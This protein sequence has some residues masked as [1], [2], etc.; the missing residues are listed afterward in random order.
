[1]KKKHLFII[2]FFGLAVT[3]MSVTAQDK[4]L[5]L[6]KS[7]EIFASAINELDKNYIENIEVEALSE[8]AT[9]AL[10]DKL[11]SY[12]SYIPFNTF[13]HVNEDKYDNGAYSGIG[14]EISEKNGKKYFSRVYK[15]TP[16]HRS[17]LQPGDEILKINGVI[18]SH[19]TAI[20]IA[21]L[22][23]GN[24][25]TTI[26]IHVQRFGLKEP[27]VVLVTR[28]KLVSYN[29]VYYNIIGNDIAYIK[30]Q[31]FGSN[32]A[33]EVKQI[34][35]NLRSKGA[36][37]LILDLRDNEGGILDE[38]V[39]LLDQFLEPETL[40][41]RTIGKTIESTKEYRISSDASDTGMPIVI[42]VNDKTASAAEIVAGAIQDHDRGIVVGRQ[43]FGKGTIQ[44]IRD[45]PYGAKIKITTAKYI[46]PSGRSI[47]I[48]A[49]KN[50]AK[51]Y[52]P[53]QFKTKSGRII[54]E[55][56]GITPDVVAPIK[57][58]SPLTLELMNF[59][60]IQ[61]YATIFRSKYKEIK[62]STDFSLSDV[63]YQ[64]FINWFLK[65]NTTLEYEQELGKILLIIDKSG[66]GESI[67]KQIL[68][69]QTQILKA[70]QAKLQQLKCEIKH[71]LEISI[72]EQYYMYE[73]GLEISFQQDVYLQKATSILQS[74]TEYEKLLGG[75]Q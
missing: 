61:N 55:Q 64:D 59:G 8:C 65:S 25:N 46:L 23:R 38:A 75:K 7:I 67:K 26:N 27:K 33:I 2:L 44:S 60:P 70:R 57:S 13:L 1:M 36:S 51:I 49:T 66:Y 62:K 14:I 71:L 74:K 43:T 42:L 24:P 6:T 39:Q 12:T 5:S 15:N 73:G 50:S 4:F 63:Q 11:D 17:G 34:L 52:K 35:S 18:V 69:L 47:S 48:D 19:K 21:S 22:V 29:V 56:N 30:L 53:K 72:A 68:G 45:L 9:S 16:A 58:L 40:V 28:E 37:K 10:T 3:L 32:A 31:E 41:V 54:Y 20:E